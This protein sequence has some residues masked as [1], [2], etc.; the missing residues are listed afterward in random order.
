MDWVKTVG[1]TGS[2]LYGIEKMLKVWRMWRAM[3]KPRPQGVTIYNGEYAALSESI[4]NLQVRIDQQSASIQTH[5]ATVKKSSASLH[6]RLAT[7]EQRVS[8]LIDRPA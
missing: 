1:V 7:L 2:A 3:S 8:R 5:F 6:R 4:Q